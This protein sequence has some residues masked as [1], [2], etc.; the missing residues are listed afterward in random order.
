M[1]FARFSRFFFAVSLHVLKLCLCNN[2]TFAIAAALNRVTQSGRHK[3]AS[4][5]AEH[6]FSSTFIEYLCRALKTGIVVF[7]L[8]LKFLSSRSS[9]QPVCVRSCFFLCI[10]ICL[11]DIC[12]QFGP[13][14]FSKKQNL[15]RG[16][17]KCQCNAKRLRCRTIIPRNN[18][19]EINLCF[20]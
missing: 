13:S 14:P 20:V 6:I 1:L 3:I 5:L 15:T 10:F 7:F 2:G 11:P 19:A 18:L 4:F 16:I 12:I 17:H 8:S 9:I